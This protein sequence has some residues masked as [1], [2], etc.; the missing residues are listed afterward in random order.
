MITVIGS[1]KLLTDHSATNKVLRAIVGIIDH[2]VRSYCRWNVFGRFRTNAGFIRNR[3]RMSAYPCV[4]NKVS[5]V[6]QG[7]TESA[8]GRR[9][10]NHKC[11]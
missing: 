3:E 4:V 5:L 8:D 6:I 2:E 7:G 9:N 11:C 1:T 10:E